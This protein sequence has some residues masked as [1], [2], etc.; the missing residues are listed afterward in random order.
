M[1]GHPRCLEY[2]PAYCG[3]PGVLARSRQHRGSAST[4][5]NFWHEKLWLYNRNLRP[6]GRGARSRTA[7]RDG[8]DRSS[9]VEKSGWNCTSVGQQCERKHGRDLQRRP[10]NNVNALFGPPRIASTAKR[11]SELE[12]TSGPR[13]SGLL[14]RRSSGRPTNWADAYGL[15]EGY[16]I[17]Q[18]HPQGNFAIN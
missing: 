13:K 14:P 4:S 11:F 7:M 18:K 10:Q 15:T 12:R 9:L 17:R 5:S 2:A 16:G 8:F 1:S 3:A 6:L